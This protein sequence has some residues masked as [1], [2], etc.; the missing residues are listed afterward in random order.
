MGT[1]LHGVWA[2]IRSP[3]S[4]EAFEDAVKKNV[5]KDAV[6]AQA[7]HGS[8]ITMALFQNLQNPLLKKYEFNAEEFV[9][10]VGPALETFH[11]V[12]MK[13]G[14]ELPTLLAE[15][16]TQK[17]TEPDLVEK[18]EST[19]ES[20]IRMDENFV[21]E[22][23]LGSN[24]WHDQ[25]KENPDSLAGRLAKM[26]TED[27]FDAFFYSAKLVLLGAP[28]KYRITVESC[29]VGEVALLNARAKVM[30]Q[31]SNVDN[32]N[33]SSELGAK[34]SSESSEMNERVAAQIDVLYEVTHTYKQPVTADPLSSTENYRD[35]VGDTQ[36]TIDTPVEKETLPNVGM[37]NSKILQSE[38]P[39]EKNEADD[40][41]Y[42]TILTTT[43]G[44]AVL[45]GWLNDGP[46][47]KDL[48]WKVALL[49][50]AH[51]F[52]HQPSITKIS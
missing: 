50:D 39:K 46:D 14:N 11:E 42:E 7:T 10:T 26:T 27:A 44:V 45:E 41:K 5:I 16:P 31:N 2:Q 8:V 34:E 13:L 29:E 51:E 9:T 40:T 28:S 33:E 3:A 52:P 1:S 24:L 35:L 15:E 38:C 37:E 12:L 43:L 30:D 49:R 20:I 36:E 6:L 48:R 32:V 17:D 22:S 4:R 19:D 18:T 25:G 21:K 23:L 47:G